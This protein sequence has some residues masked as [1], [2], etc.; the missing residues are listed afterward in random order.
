M[1]TGGGGEHL[2]LPRPDRPSRCAIAPQLGPGLDVRGVGGYVVAPPYSYQRN[3]YAWNVDPHPDEV[4]LAKLPAFWCRLPRPTMKRRRQGNG[5]TLCTSDFGRRSQSGDCPP[6]R[7]SFAPLRRPHIT[8]QFCRFGIGHCYPPL[9]ED[10]VSKIIESICR[11][12]LARRKAEDEKRDR[13]R[14]RRFGQLR[15]RFE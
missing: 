9:A 14:R 12:E 11:R 13:R 10:E 15:V 3:Q 2:L 8:V 4:P 5:G 7:S 6:R 1:F